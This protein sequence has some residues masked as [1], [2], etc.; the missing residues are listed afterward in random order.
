LLLMMV[1]SV[2][3]IVVDGVR[4]MMGG[5]NNTAVHYLLIFC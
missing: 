3:V 4:W 2:S 5:F 1:V